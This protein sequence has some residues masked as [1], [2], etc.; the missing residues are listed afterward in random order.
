MNHQAPETKN[1]Q[2]ALF[3]LNGISS[4]TALTMMGYY[5]FFTQNILG[6]S[7]VVVGMVATL[8]RVFDGITDPPIGV[9]IDRTNTKF[10]RFRPFMMAGCILVALSQIAIFNTPA[11]FGVQGGYIFT[12]LAYVVYVLGYTF[13]TT[14]TRAAQAILTKNPKQRPMFAVWNSGFNAI[15]SAVF[16]LIL[17]TWMAP[18]YEGQLQ[19]PQ[20]W[21]YMSFITAGIMVVCSV[22]ACIGLASRDV[23]E[24]YLGAAKAQKVGFKDMWNV[25]KGNRA[26]QMLVIAASTDKLGSMLKNGMMIYLFSN[27]FLNSKMQGAVSSIFIYRSNN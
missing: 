23:P 5:M 24:V 8:M 21:S 17:M 16:P 22:L 7:A 18:N 2:I 4:N 6:L 15:L 27:C 19:N 10:G 26:L 14:C 3:S 1:W 9:L 12:T 25:I 13:Q 20:L 11:S